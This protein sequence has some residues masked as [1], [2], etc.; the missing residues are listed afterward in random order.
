MS[1]TFDPNAF[2]NED[3]QTP[4]EQASTQS[5]MMPEGGV[6]LEG[7]EFNPEQFL[8]EAK[9]EQYGS[10][11]QQALAGVEGLASG[12]LG[13]IAPL[14]QTKVL[15]QKAEDIRAREEV[16]PITS[17]AGEATG[18]IGSMIAGVGLGGAMA[19][20]GK[21]AE[22]A[23][24]LTKAA[25]TVANKIGS[26]AV[27]QAA[28]MAVM[29]SSDE[30]AKVIL[31]DPESSAESAVSNIGLAAVLGGLGGAA[32]G[33]VSPLWKATVGPGVEKGWNMVANRV[34]GRPNLI[35]PEAREQAI[36]TLG[37]EVDPLVKGAL[38]DDVAYRDMFNTAKRSENI[39]IA[40]ALSKFET[41]T[42]EAVAKSL[43][44]SADDVLYYDKN[45]AGKDLYGA[46]EREYKAKYQPLADA[47]EKRNAEAA[48]IT[49]SD[50]ARL[51]MRDKLIER[52]M[53][54]FTPNSAGAKAYQKYADDLLN[55][56]TVGRLDQLRTEL[57]Q[58]ARGITT[59]LNEKAALNDIRSMLGEFQE[60]QIARMA[61]QL[62]QSGVK[63]ARK[64]AASLMAERSEAARQYAEFAKMSNELAE[65]LGVGNF[66][67]FG[68]LT[69][70]LSDKIT[71]EQLMNKFSVKNNADFIPF[72]EKHFPDTLAQVLKN[73]R[74]DM[75]RPAV[76]SA[77]KKGENP[78]DVNKLADILQR[79]MS[80]RSSVVEKVIPQD[81]ILKAQAA[82]DLYNALP[83]VKDSG[84][85]AG[86]AK[87]F[88]ALPTS[89]TA[90]IGWLMGNNPITSGMVGLI[91][92]ELGMK[93]PNVAR[94]TYLKLLTASEPVSAPGIKA[95]VDF[96]DATYKAENAFSKNIKAVFKG[97]SQVLA[98]N[99]IPS[100][101]DLEK[102]DKMVDKSIS[103]PEMLL[104][105]QMSNDIGYYMPEHAAALSKTTVGA[106]K[107]LEG[108][109]PKEFRPG[110]L[111]AP[112]PPS[113]AELSRYKRALAI[114]QNPQ[115]IL[116]K[117][118]DGELITSDIQDLQGMYPGLYKTM[119]N[120]L[121]TQMLDKTSMDEAI[122]YKTR[123]AL[124]LFMGQP[125][126]ASM[127]PQNIM[128]AQM[129]PQAGQPQQN[130][131]KG[132]PSALKGDSADAAMTAGQ[133]AEANRPGNR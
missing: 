75:I 37:I 102:L 95:M 38:S 113:K 110:P 42:S 130:T 47:F 61:D 133:K 40:N 68:S 125:L 128:S 118:K 131:S 124:S 45:T 59:D 8:Q 72:L 65:N 77:A 24:G 9:E 48:G 70:K 114:A 46:F 31:S 121:S 55:L 129:K 30:V 22:A 39:E 69:N 107:Y 17:G 84:T 52:G 99:M 29:Q 33:S 87:L 73:E 23:V 25:P 90:A 28:E 123:I 15:G 16:N 4:I 20:A 26:L 32:F 78:I 98:S 53:E 105:K 82:R 81:A 80:E 106:L 100:D 18:L 112:I 122:P 79:Q 71:A 116:K 19:K 1:D 27:Q 62:E 58:T 85:P 21:A 64:E 91:G 12:V 115:I 111:D 76:L 93:L 119:V 41:D 11:G 5:M 54:R 92:S 120:K 51:T 83:K 57:G 49:L 74:Q 117:I 43:G 13:P 66:K 34:N 126:D 14:I 63:G 103:N 2:L 109:K 108:I 44:L 60:N 67:G 127:S 89:A 10:L 88:R 50:E 56:E 7:T 86:M 132:R 94:M 96:L 3:E 36:K 35:L 101:K 97:S 104:S 6:T